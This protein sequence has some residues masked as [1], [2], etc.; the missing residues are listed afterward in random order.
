MTTPTVDVFVGAAG[1]TTARCNQTRKSEGA[2][3]QLD[4][5]YFR[6]L[7]DDTLQQIADAIELYLIR[8]NQRQRKEKSK[9]AIAAPAENPEAQK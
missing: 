3:L 5:V 8:K 9:P 2:T 1:L 4:R 7:P 6:D